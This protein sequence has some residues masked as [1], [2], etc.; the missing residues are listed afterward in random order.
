MKYMLAIYGN[1]EKWDSFTPEEFGPIIAE[2]DALNRALL[3]SGEMIGAYGVADASEAITV[4]MVDGVPAVTDGPY[5]EAKECLGSFSILE[6]DSLERAIEIAALN[7]V[8]RY[9]AVEL[10]ELPHHA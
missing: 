7:P 3:A 5:I 2:T 9:G 10:V 8:S 1:Q 6:V 4:R